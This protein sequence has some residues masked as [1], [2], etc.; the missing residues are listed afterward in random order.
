MKMTS[1]HE[2]LQA[3]IY[4]EALTTVFT[5][6]TKITS[7]H[8]SLQV[9]ETERRLYSPLSQMCFGNILEKWLTYVAKVGLIIILYENDHY[10]QENAIKPGQ[11]L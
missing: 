10:C 4:C 9:T 8:D 3:F 2:Y 7:P 5:R 1:S 6:E 11:C